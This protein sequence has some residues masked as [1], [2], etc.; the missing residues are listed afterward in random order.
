MVMEYFTK[1]KRKP[2]TA[3]AVADE[4]KSPLL[5]DEDEKFLERLT[6]AAAGA[7]EQAP[8]L[9]DRPVVIFEGD[10]P[11]Q[12]K[13]AQTA[14]MDGADHVALP[15]SPPAVEGSTAKSSGSKAGKK[16]AD[17]LTYAKSIPGMLTA[18]VSYPQ[19]GE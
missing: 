18:K 7:E 9:P 11:V 12:G 16:A 1:H 2:S 5:N 4:P 17:Y 15:S 3:V 14:L 10:K 8:P 19:A 13:D 6:A